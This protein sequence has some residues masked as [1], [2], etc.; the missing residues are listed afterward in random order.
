MG[1]GRSRDASRRSIE[2]AALR[3]FAER[4]VASTS[5]GVICREAGVSPATFYRCF[6]SKE[7]VVFTYQPEFL[8]AL[9]RALAGVVDRA[10]DVEELAGAF[11]AFL[12]ARRERVFVLD[13]L[14]RSNPELMP[15]MLTFQRR[16]EQVL[17]DALV[18]AG[19][20]DGHDAQLMGALVVAVLRNAMRRAGDRVTAIADE[21]PA[22]IGRLGS[23]TAGQP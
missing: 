17:V 21:V 20:L 22:V 11:A 15:R 16:W 9:D 19:R 12:D 8:D 5:V 18:R 4:G 23:V 3:L 13:R 2:D 10:P 14:V 1:A 7:D 6:A